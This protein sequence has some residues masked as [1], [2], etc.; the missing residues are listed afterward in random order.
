AIEA[1][2]HR[3]PARPGQLGASA[4][5]IVARK[6]FSLKERES[7]LSRITMPNQT[8]CVPCNAPAAKK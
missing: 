2:G 5:Q 1:A 3:H 7:P 4:G 6:R 8:D